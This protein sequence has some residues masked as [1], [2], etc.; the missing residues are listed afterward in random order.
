MEKQQKI[1]ELFSNQESL[2]EFLSQETPQDA[3]S[4]LASKG[5]DFSLAEIE[6]LGK[7]IVKYQDSGELSDEELAEI[8]GGKS[9]TIELPDIKKI[10][11]E[12][13]IPAI[14]NSPEAIGKASGKVAST[15]NIIKIKFKSG[16]LKGYKK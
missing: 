6:T 5:I 9:I 3:Q 8:T 13:I 7:L 16:W 12:T 14:Q 11:N 10:F 15:L 2:N 4:F 1:K